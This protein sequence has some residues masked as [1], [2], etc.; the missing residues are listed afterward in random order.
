M[1]KKAQEVLVQVLLEPVIFKFLIFAS[2]P[3]PL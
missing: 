1:T 3:C 2:H